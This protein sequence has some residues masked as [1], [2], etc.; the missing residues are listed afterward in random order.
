MNPML[1]VAILLSCCMLGVIETL[2]CSMA[3]LV[4]YLALILILPLP[5][6]VLLLAGLIDLFY[7]NT[8][9]LKNVFS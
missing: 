7:P 3:S 6:A 5:Q 8:K 1:A 9:R 4:V 2:L